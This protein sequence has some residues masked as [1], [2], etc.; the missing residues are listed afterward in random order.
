MP[1]VGPDDLFDLLCGTLAGWQGA[2]GVTVG[3]VQ[4][5]HINGGLCSQAGLTQHKGVVAEVP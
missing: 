2:G 5:Q 1:W 3:V 4:V